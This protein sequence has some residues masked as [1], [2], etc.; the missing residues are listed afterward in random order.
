MDALMFIGGGTLCLLAL[1]SGGPWWL[2]VLGVIGIP[3][4]LFGATALQE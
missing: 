2:V 4:C 1:S 3:L